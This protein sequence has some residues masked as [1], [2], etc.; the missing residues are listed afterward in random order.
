MIAARAAWLRASAWLVLS[1]AAVPTA[2]AATTFEFDAGALGAEDAAAAHRLL[3]AAAGQLPPGW[4]AALPDTLSVQWRDDLPPHVSGR[5]FGHQLRLDRQLLTAWRH[6]SPP[7]QDPPVR[8]ALG[9]VLHELAHVLDRSAAGGLSRDRRL[10]ALAGWPQRRVLPGRLDNDF[11]DR[12]PDLYEVR[13]P[14]EFVAV[15]LEHF[16]LDADYACRRPALA[17]W[18]RTRLGAP[19]ISPTR[20]SIGWPY[21]VADGSDGAAQ[22]ETLP[23]ARVYAIDYLFAEGDPAM[24]MSRWG[25]S[26]LRLVICAPERPPG[27]DCRLDLRYH[28]V[29]SFR[30]FI[31]DVQI[32]SWQGLTGGYPSRLYVL[33]LEQVI[34]EYTQVQLRSLSSWP[35]ALRQEDIAAV[36][37][38]AARVHWNYDGR[39]RFIGNN[40]AVETWKLLHDAVEPV[41]ALHWRGITPSGLLERLREAG[42]VDDT[43]LQDRQRAA[44]EGYYFVSASARYQAMFEVLQAGLPLNVDTLE[45]WFALAPSSR[46]EWIDRAGLRESA[47]LLLLEQAAQRR[48]ELRARDWIKRQWLGNSEGR[49]RAREQWA[50]VFDAADALARPAALLQGVGGYG[51]PQPTELHALVPRAEERNQRLVEGWPALRAQAR[52]ALPMAQQDEWAQI[53]GNLVH[54]Q[55]RLRQLAS[56]AEQPPNAI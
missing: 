26:M 53:D 5:S 14:R 47:A 15:N 27:P 37:E 52:A 28:R 46:A 33:P 41:A 40:C 22:L 55:Q 50:G 3:D 48:Q 34:D 4:A 54:I 9:T 23:A 2:V 25:H 16:A 18:F 29:L 20:C 35:L 44:R 21:L 11:S 24:P 8:L 12:S 32:S 19:A 51:I 42:Q 36:L 13:D 38:R 45:A 31:G 49:T 6:P 10:E 1:I 7:W 30:A 43:P 39:Y 17:A 56:E